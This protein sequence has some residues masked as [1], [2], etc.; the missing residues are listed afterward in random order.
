MDSERF[1][2]TEL[3][4]IKNRFSSFTIM[5]KVKLRIIEIYICKSII[6]RIHIEM[7]CCFFARF[8]F[9]RGY[10]S[11]DSQ[12]RNIFKGIIENA[13]SE[14]FHAI[15][16]YNIFQ[17]SAASEGICSDFFK[18]WHIFEEPCIADF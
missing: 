2:R 11:R 1:S 7:P 10:G 17:L 15:R 5:I 16:N 9:K 14:R 12:L 6:A 8:L 18:V 3:I 13:V 4:G